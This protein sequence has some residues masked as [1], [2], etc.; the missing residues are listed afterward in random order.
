MANGLREV[1]E[2]SP[3]VP[4]WQEFG[5]PNDRDAGF[6]GFVLAIGHSK[7]KVHKNLIYF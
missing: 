1:K 7:Y 3:I 6:A 4:S 2:T 5:S